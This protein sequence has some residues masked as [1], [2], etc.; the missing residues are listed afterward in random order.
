L[1]TAA[2]TR[3]IRRV[4]LG[5]VLLKRLSKAEFQGCQICS[6]LSYQKCQFRY[7][8]IRRLWDGNFGVF[9]RHLGYLLPFG[10]MYIL[11]IWN[12]GT[13]SLFE[14]LY[15]DKSGNPDEFGNFQ[16]SLHKHNLGRI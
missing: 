7:R 1:L 6:I 3:L 12:F 13:F 8:Y 14:F 10:Y 2:L 11:F 16:R 4:E 5:V 15:H 9:R